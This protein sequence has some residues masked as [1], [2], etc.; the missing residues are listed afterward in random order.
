M[1]SINHVAKIY[2][3]VAIAIHQISCVDDRINF[4]VVL[5]YILHTFIYT[6]MHSS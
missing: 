2:Q 5:F 3:T 6:H 1:Y 4:E